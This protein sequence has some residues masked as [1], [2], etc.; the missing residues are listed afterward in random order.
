MNMLDEEGDDTFHGTRE[1]YSYL[2]ARFRGDRSDDRLCSIRF[3]SRVVS[4][5]IVTTLSDAE[6]SAVERMSST[7]GEGAVW[8]LLSSRDRDQQHFIIA[9]FLQEELDASRAEVTLLHQHGHQ[10][11]ELLRQQQSQS[12]TAVSTRERRRETLTLEV[13]KYRGVEEDSLLR[14]FLEVD[15]AVKA[16]HIDNEEMQVAFAKSNLSGVPELGP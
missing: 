8:S 11:T 2:A 1:S 6:W 7:V 14:W 5:S 3:D 4:F 10:Q 15:D 13:S 16:R 12:A 9:K